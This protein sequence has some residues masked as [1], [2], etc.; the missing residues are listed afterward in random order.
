MIDKS[1]ISFGKQIPGELLVKNLEVR[2]K[3]PFENW[4]TVSGSKIEL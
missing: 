2:C 4:L 1:I 3:K